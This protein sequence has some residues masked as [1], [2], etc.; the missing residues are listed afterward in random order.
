MIA[1][2][3]CY[4]MRA[5]ASASGAAL[6]CAACMLARVAPGLPAGIIRWR[7]HCAALR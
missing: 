1:L 4:Q 6:C 7:Q 2:D 5:A 3:V